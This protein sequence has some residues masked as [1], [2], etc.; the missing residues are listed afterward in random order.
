MRKYNTAISLAFSSFQRLDK[1]NRIHHSLPW[2]FLDAEASFFSLPL[3]LLLPPSGGPSCIFFPGYGVIVMAGT[4]FPPLLVSPVRP[5]SGEFSTKGPFGHKL[6]REEGPQLSLPSLFFSF[7]FL[8]SGSGKPGRR[9]HLFL[10][11]HI[12]LRD[13]APD[14]VEALSLSFLF[15]QGF[16]PPFSLFPLGRRHPPPPPPPYGSVGDDD[17]KDRDRRRLLPGLFL[18]SG[19]RRGSRSNGYA[20]LKAASRTS[21]LFSLAFFSFSLTG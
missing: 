11:D 9:S 14:T 15:S 17:R 6:D 8:L 20:S 2:Q 7:F 19:P 16:N 13:Q 4:S 12:W 10:C 5:T 1:Q 18:P 21:P 3:L